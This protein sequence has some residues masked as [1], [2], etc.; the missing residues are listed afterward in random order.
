MWHDGLII[1]SGSGRN[2][3]LVPYSC[4]LMDK[5]K[6]LLTPKVEV[7]ILPGV[8]RVGTHVASTAACKAA[9]SD[10]GGSTPPP[11]TM[12]SKP[13]GRGHP[14]D[15]R[16]ERG[17]IPRRSTNV[18]ATV[19]TG[20]GGTPLPSW[21]NALRARKGTTPRPNLVRGSA[22]GLTTDWQRGWNPTE[23]R[24]DSHCQV[25]RHLVQ[26]ESC[27]PNLPHNG[28]AVQRIK[29]TAVL[30]QRAAAGSH[31]WASRGTAAASV[32]KTGGAKARAGSIPAPS[33]KRPDPDGQGSGCNPAQAGSTPAGRSTE[34][35][36]D[37]CRTPVA[38]RAGAQARVGSTPTPSA[39]RCSV[40]TRAWAPARR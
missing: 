19:S 33:A 37:G 2:R 6:G 34:G 29:G 30:G 21:G 7:R 3:R 26:V 32:S 40:S 17:S 18:E 10:C 39:K 5:S 15:K 23:G 36:S 9:V 13:T 28:W 14:S 20:S 31:G 22:G 38:N 24:G 35:P 1:R 11:C 25:D 16:E 8:L 12:L 4:S 27:L